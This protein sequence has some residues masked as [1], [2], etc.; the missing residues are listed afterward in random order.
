M[1]IIKVFINEKEID[2]IHIWNTGEC[3]NPEL[4]MWKYKILKPEGFEDWYIIHNRDTGY[5]N[6]LVEVLEIIRKHGD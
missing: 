5:M 3:T 1:M 2:E 4:N 6:L